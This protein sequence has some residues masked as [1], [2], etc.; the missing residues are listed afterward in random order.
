MHCGFNGGPNLAESVNFMGWSVRSWKYM[1]EAQKLLDRNTCDTCRYHMYCDVALMGMFL[2]V[3]FC[4]KEKKSK[5]H[6]VSTCVHTL[7]FLFF[8]CLYFMSCNKKNTLSLFSVFNLF[9]SDVKAFSLIKIVLH[10]RFSLI[11]IT[12]QNT[13]KSQKKKLFFIEI[14]KKKNQKKRS[15]NCRLLGQT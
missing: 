11:R 3:F 4:F 5:F 9:F 12:T 8:F 1:F 10:C 13:N 7:S 15:K 2:C 6:N 14:P